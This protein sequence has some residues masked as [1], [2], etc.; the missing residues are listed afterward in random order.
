MALVLGDQKIV[1]CLMEW[2]HTIHRQNRSGKLLFSR[3]VKVNA[4]PMVRF[5]LNNDPVLDFETVQYVD[6]ASCRYSE[7]NADTKLQYKS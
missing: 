2:R 1:E 4:V 3:V 7:L 5:L 6:T